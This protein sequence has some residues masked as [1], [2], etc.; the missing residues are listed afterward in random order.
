MRVIIFRDIEELVNDIVVELKP[1]EF[2]EFNKRLQNITT[3]K[4]SIIKKLL[5]RSDN[6]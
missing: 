4:K 5:K 6:K 1:T 3:P 2:I